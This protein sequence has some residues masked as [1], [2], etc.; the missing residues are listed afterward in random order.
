MSLMKPLVAIAAIA[1]LAAACSKN[2]DTAAETTPTT[3]TDP[4]MTGSSTD[5]SATAPMSGDAASATGSMGASGDMGASGQ[6]GASGTV[7][8]SGTTAPSNTTGAVGPTNTPQFDSSNPV[9]ENSSDIG[10]RR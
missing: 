9:P 10:A 6:T 4:A 5:V 2:E 8:N 1:V 3:A 7:T